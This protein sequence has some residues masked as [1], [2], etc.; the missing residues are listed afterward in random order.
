M[1]L[2]LECERREVEI[3]AVRENDLCAIRFD[4]EPLDVALAIPPVTGPSVSVL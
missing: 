2:G 4:R 3:V 1:A